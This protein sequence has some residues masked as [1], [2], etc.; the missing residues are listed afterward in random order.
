MISA[1]AK[2]TLLIYLEGSLRRTADDVSHYE[3]IVEQKKRIRVLCRTEAEL[4]S[5][6]ETVAHFQKALEQRVSWHRD[7]QQAVDEL[8]GLQSTPVE[9]DKQ[10]G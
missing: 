10:S 6:D 4:A 2:A 3:E 8:R 5:N 9:G 7:L 1:A